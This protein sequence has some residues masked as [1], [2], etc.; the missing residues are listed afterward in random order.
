MVLLDDG[1][2]VIII[3]LNLAQH[4]F[5]ASSEIFLRRKLFVSLLSIR[6]AGFCVKLMQ[7]PLEIAR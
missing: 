2:F 4:P 5:F 7:M 3:G 6:A 1:I